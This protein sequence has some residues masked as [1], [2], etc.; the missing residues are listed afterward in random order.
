MTFSP[1]S[2]ALSERE[3]TSGSETPSLSAG[4][5]SRSGQGRP[6][7]ER[8]APHGLLDRRLVV[9]TGKGGV[10]KTSVCAALATAAA[11]AGTRTLAVELGRDA[12]LPALVGNAVES[13]LL[14]PY[15]ALAE[16][17][18]LQLGFGGL[19][20]RVMGH[21]GFRQLLEG[22]PGWRELIS[23]GKVWHLV[24]RGD[25]ETGPELVVV[26]AP[27]T[28]HSTTFLDVPRVAASA[29]RSGPLHRHASAVEALLR[30][31]ERCVLLPVC[32]PEELA[33]RECVEL[34]A[35]IRELELPVDRVVM[36]AAEAD[37]G[38]DVDSLVAALERS[39]PDGFPWTRALREWETRHQRTLR[40]GEFVAR[41]TGLPLT[42]LPFSATGAADAL[43]SMGEALLGGDAGSD[44]TR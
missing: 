12:E 37:P 28:G 16:Y 33:A 40:W 17:L 10:G 25:P 41:E 7:E 26:D 1:H 13:Q 32:R 8:E 31:P 44:P 3:A 21:P 19:L 15:D 34:V 9:V 38:V 42:R 30:D 24:E 5:L 14:D 39:A 20:A 36:N 27:A 11:A 23:V 43:A 29:V 22:A 6:P 4:S 2:P 18:G 35:R